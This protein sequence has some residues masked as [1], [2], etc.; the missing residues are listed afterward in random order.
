MP[1]PGMLPAATAYTPTFTPMP[2]LSRPMPCIQ[3]QNL[4]N[5]STPH[6]I[7]CPSPCFTDAFWPPRLE[8][9]PDPS[10]F[11]A[12]G[13]YTHFTGFTRWEPGKNGEPDGNTF[14]CPH[15]AC[16][17]TF[18]RRKHVKGHI[19]CMYTNDEGWICQY[20]GGA[21]EKTFPRKG[22]YRQ[23]VWKNHPNQTWVN[24]T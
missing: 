12:E 13:A 14:L 7:K 3:A 21:C 9:V 19:K 22:N 1:N 17:G 6:R 2:G 23:Q 15:A 20:G 8:L 18:K 5:S 10:L 24:A 4:S 16:A 11:P